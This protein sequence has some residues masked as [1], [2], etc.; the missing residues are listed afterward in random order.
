MARKSDNIKTEK[1]EVKN[2]NNLKDNLNFE[3]GISNTAYTIRDEVFYLGKTIFNG[4][5]YVSALSEFLFNSTVPFPVA[6]KRVSGCYMFELD[7]NKSIA[8]VKLEDK[9]YFFE[10]VPGSNPT[11][12][13]DVTISSS[14]REV[15]LEAIF[16]ST[17]KASTTGYSKYVFINLPGEAWVVAYN[18]RIG[19]W[20]IEK[21]NNT[22]SAWTGT[23]AYSLGNRRIPT[24]A[25]GYY[26]EITVAG[27]SSGVEP[28]WP[29][30]I[31][32]TVVDGTATWICRGRYNNFPTTTSSSVKTLN[33]YIFVCVNGDIYNSDLDIPDSWNTSDFISTEIFPDNIVALAKYK[34]YLVAL[35]Q[36]TI[37]FFY[38][39]AN[40]SGTPLA[41]QEGILH[42]IGCVGQAMVTDIEDKVFWIS[43]TSSQNYS[44]W[45][46]E[47]FEAKKISTPEVDTWLSNLLADPVLY[48]PTTIQYMFMFLFRLNGRLM[49]GIPDMSFGANGTSPGSAQALFVL[50]LEIGS[51]YYWES[52]TIPCQKLSRPFIWKNYFLWASNQLQSSNNN[53]VF[54]CLGITDYDRN[55]VGAAPL[56][57]QTPV[58]ITRRL[59]FGTTCYKTLHEVQINTFPGTSFSPSFSV[60][61][62]KGSVTSVPVPAN[63]Y[64]AHR[65]GR[66][67]EFQ[68]RFSGPGEVSSIVCKYSEHS[69]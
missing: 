29:T 7:S 46:L 64:K 47:K 51:S 61:R 19:A 31:G 26:Y 58:F 5:P 35:G 14:N 53:L 27:T 38:D 39:A 22:Y 17:E 23:T 25:N 11:T 60:V 33:G 48:A 6:S 45:T 10:H 41:R 9:I 13:S 68:L 12:I 44:I 8:I 1:I 15:Y 52:D 54:T 55:L 30:T 36:N 50:D 66:A 63:S 2:F 67:R 28:T 20:Q 40:T 69:N 49:L 24:V 16:C 34:N 3:P 4:Y 21:V 32:N 56:F 57:R 59:N 42:N 18:T 43:Q 65:L 62:D 37:E